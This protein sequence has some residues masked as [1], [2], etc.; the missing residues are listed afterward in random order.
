MNMGKAMTYILRERLVGQIVNNSKRTGIVA[1]PLVCS[2]LA[3]HVDLPL[4]IA[5]GTVG[6]LV[7][8]IATEPRKPRP[9]M[10][11]QLYRTTQYL[12][13]NLAPMVDSAA[14]TPCILF[15]IGVDEF[16][17]WCKRN[18]KSDRHDVIT[19]LYDRLAGVVRHDDLVIHTADHRFYIGIA[20]RG[21]FDVNTTISIAQ[22]LQRAV[23]APFVIRD[24]PHYFSVSIGIA[25]TRMDGIDA[26]ND[27]CRA[28]TMAT[29]LAAD[30]GAGSVRFFPQGGAQIKDIEP[31]PTAPALQKAFE[32]GEIQAHFQP[33][34]CGFTGQILGFEAL[35]RW[36]KPNGTMIAPLKFLDVLKSS[37]QLI[38]LTD[39][40][41]SQSL[42]A[43]KN[44]QS[45]G[46]S[47]ATVSVN[48]SADDVN[49]PNLVRRIAHHLKHA[50]VD[51]H[52]LILEIVEDV[53]ITSGTSIVAKN[54]QGLVDLGCRIDLDDFGTGNAS[55][56]MLR[57][58]KLHRIKIDR[59]FLTQCDQDETQQRMLAAIISMAHEMGLQVVAEG[60]ETIAEQCEAVRQG[61][62]ALQGYAIA[63]PMTRTAVRD[64][65]QNYTNHRFHAPRTA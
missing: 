9:T 35:A 62:D 63:K 41:V 58:L 40:M 60:I 45:L 53:V 49:D 21:V 3:A 11:R 6:S 32:R 1:M 23:D 33:Q 26:G 56:P 34:V 10:G 38:A 47:I 8:L 30:Q 29:T 2:A 64:W 19:A 5:C 14:H 22:R 15:A 12:I 18:S 36:M 55:I 39:L 65:V 27:L 51:A 13:T 59:G 25:D 44:W 4:A 20:M 16:D 50:K 57:H 7:S 24:R 43:W 46:L 31:R 48:L 42:T 52:H 37:G 28:A 54:I 17:L 61:V